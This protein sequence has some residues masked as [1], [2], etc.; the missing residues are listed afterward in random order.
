[1]TPRRIRNALAYFLWLLWQIILSTLQVVRV[2]IDP[3]LGRNGIFMVPLDAATKAEILILA[4]SITLTPGTISVEMGVNTS[5][6]QA[7]F[8]HALVLDDAEAA[9]V[10]IKSTFE[11]RIL[12]FTRTASAHAGTNVKGAHT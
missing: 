1:M 11:S 6:Q 10:A 2:I 5:G 3:R 7:L 12:S 4:T 9:A 8:V